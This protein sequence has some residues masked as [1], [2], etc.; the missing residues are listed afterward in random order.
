MSC[1]SCIYMPHPPKHTYKSCLCL[2][3]LHAA[4][5]RDSSSGTRISMHQCRYRWSTLAQGNTDGCSTQVLLENVI[6]SQ[7]SSWGN[8]GKCVAS[9]VC[10]RLPLVRCVGL[11]CCLR[12]LTRAES[13]R[14]VTTHHLQSE[15]SF[16]EPHC[17]VTSAYPEYLS[18]Y[19]AVCDGAGK[20]QLQV[21]GGVVGRDLTGLND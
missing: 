13:E 5:V 6:V 11:C 20:L 10:A 1:I 15:P 16:L 8:V 9:S 14:C 21:R 18:F 7:W 3:K 17:K 12:L 4:G 2:T 19:P